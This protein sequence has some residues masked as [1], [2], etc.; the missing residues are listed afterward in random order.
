[1]RDTANNAKA[2]G[3]RCGF[4]PGLAT[5]FTQTAL[6]G[7]DGH[8]YFE[9]DALDVSFRTARVKLATASGSID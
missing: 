7:P 5:D 2:P 3:R 9:D 8:F 4:F 1:V 6:L